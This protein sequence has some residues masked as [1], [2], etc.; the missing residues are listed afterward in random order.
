[1]VKCKVKINEDTWTVRTVGTKEMQKER[2]DG[3]Y[4]AGLCITG[5][6]TILIHIEHLDDAT[7]CHELYH[8]YFHYLHLDDTNDLSV[9]D[10]EEISASFFTEKAATILT[11]T[12]KITKKLQKLYAKELEK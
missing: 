3:E 12:K 1:M 5:R 4:I 8:A 2:E 10:F 9:G 11:K 7:V 6:K